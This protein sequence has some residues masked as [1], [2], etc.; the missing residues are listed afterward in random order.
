MFSE[1]IRFPYRGDLNMCV[2]GRMCMS[3]VQFNS[4]QDGVYALWKA[5]MRSTPSL[6][7]VPSVAFETVPMLVCLTM[8]R[9]RPPQGR[10]VERFLFLYAS[11]LQAI[12]GVMPLALCSVQKM[13]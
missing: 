11:L 9:S 6:R 2:G 7:S 13:I 8:A 10:S 5:H 4:I 3:S 12:D 1:Q